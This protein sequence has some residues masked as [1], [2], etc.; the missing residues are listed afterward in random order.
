[1]LTVIKYALGGTFVALLAMLVVILI[2]TVIVIM[3]DKP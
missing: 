2:D 1:M 3:R